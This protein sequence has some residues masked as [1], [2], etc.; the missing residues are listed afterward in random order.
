MDAFDEFSEELVMSPKP[1]LN[2]RKFEG[3][4]VHLHK[5]RETLV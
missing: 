3:V 5:E 4:Q 1:G 2:I